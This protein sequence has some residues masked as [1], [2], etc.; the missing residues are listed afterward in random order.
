MRTPDLRRLLD[1]LDWSNEATLAGASALPEDVLRADVGIS[2]GS[3][4]G[5]LRHMLWAERLWFERWARGADPVG[6]EAPED[7]AALTDAWRT[8]AD[9]R[10][11][12]VADL[13]DDAPEGDCVYRRGGGPEQRAN[14]GDLVTHAVTHA[15]LH[16][17]QVVGM[18]RQAGVVPPATGMLSFIREGR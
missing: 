2:F 10:R 14:L 18:M 13:T 11:A 3:I 6:Y 17:G 4:L 8:L 1:N 12:W 9:E 7:L 15:A 16:R 5:T